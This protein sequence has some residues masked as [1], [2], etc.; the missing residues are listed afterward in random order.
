[1]MDINDVVTLASSG[2]VSIVIELQPSS[3]ST[4]ISGINE[5]RKRLQVKVTSPALK[6]AANEDLINL[7]SDFFGLPNSSVKIDSGAKDRRKRILLSDISLELVR[8][9]LDQYLGN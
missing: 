1:M 2:E 5:W 7:M 9:K 4:E 8:E 3:S 6:G